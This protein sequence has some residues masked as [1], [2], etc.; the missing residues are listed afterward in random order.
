MAMTI[1]DYEERIAKAEERLKKIDK[2][3]QKWEDNKSDKNFAKQYDWSYD[4]DLGWRI[5]WNN[6][7]KT[8]GTFDQFKARYYA[9]WEEK[10]NREIRAATIDKEDTI[11]LINKYKNAIELLK[12]KDAKPVIQIFRDFFDQWKETIKDYV[13]PLVKEYYEVDNKLVNIHNNRRRFQELSFASEEELKAEEK[14][15]ST[16]KK[17]IISEPIVRV[18]IEKRFKWREYDFNKYLDDYMNDRY[19]ELV[20]KVTKIVGEIEDVSNLHLGIDG[21]LNGKVFGT[22]GGAKIES[23]I[24]GG[25]NDDRIVNVK[26][27]QCRHYRVLVH[28]IK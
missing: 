21:T 19:F 2:R 6:N 16:L 9:E 20:D 23:I 24:A 15:L 1:R 22:N 5:A 7:E 10:C 13:R 28:Q 4:E 12:E 3:I 14:R 26:R 18:A 17:K 27:G 25:Y 11:N 8:Y